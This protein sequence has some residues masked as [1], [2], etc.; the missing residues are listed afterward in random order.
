M[1]R[2]AVVAL[3]VALFVATASAGYTNAKLEVFTDA[4]CTVYNQF[5]GA[6][7]IFTGITPSVCTNRSNVILIISPTSDTQAT[8]SSQ[9]S[10]MTCSTCQISSVSVTKNACTSV[11][12]GYWGKITWDLASTNTPGSAGTCSFSTEVPIRC[13]HIRAPSPSLLNS[14]RPPFDC[15]PP[16]RRLRLLRSHVSVNP[17]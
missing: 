9:C 13:P 6:N 2:L 1:A 10:D 16:P 5:N 17:T 3:F 4:A 14:C 15:C 12:S 7:M 8:I 11:V